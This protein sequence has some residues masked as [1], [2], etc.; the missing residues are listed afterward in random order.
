[1]INFPFFHVDIVAQI[2]H[3]ARDLFVTGKE[4]FTVFKFKVGQP[5]I[6]HR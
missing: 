4:L 3:S 1:M 6:L 5:K 2:L